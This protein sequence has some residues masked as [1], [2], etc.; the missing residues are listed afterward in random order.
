M[1]QQ[2]HKQEKHSNIWQI[3]EAKARFSEVI[4]NATTKG[5][6]TIT[7]L[8]EPVAIII[9]KKEFDKMQRP[10]ISLL[11]F[12]KNAPCPEIDLDIKRSRDLPRD[13]EL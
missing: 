3:Q 7:K 5:Y 4:S 12:F 6:Q 10:E 9:S 1:K 13:I 8:G 11:D 2:H